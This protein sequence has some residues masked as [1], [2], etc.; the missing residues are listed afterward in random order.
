MSTSTVPTYRGFLNITS[1]HMTKQEMQKSKGFL[2]GYAQNYFKDT[3]RPH[4]TRPNTLIYKLD[5]TGFVCFDTDDKASNDFIMSVMEKYNVPANRNKSVSNAFTPTVD[6]SAHK[7][8][9]WF[10][11]DKKYEKQIGT[12]NPAYPKLDLLTKEIV[13]EPIVEGQFNIQDAPILTDEIYKEIKGAGAVA[14]FSVHAE[15]NESEDKE[16]NEDEDEDEEPEAEA[17]AEQ[18]VSQTEMEARE[19]IDTHTTPKDAKTYTTWRNTIFKIYN[20]FGRTTLGLKMAKYFSAKDKKKY[21]EADVGLFWNKIE[22]KKIAFCE[23]G[24]SEIEMKIRKEEAKNALFE[25]I[26]LEKEEQ[27]MQK[28]MQQEEQ[29]K[30]KSK[31]S[32]DKSLSNYNEAFEKMKAEFEKENFKVVQNSCFVQ[33]TFDEEH[34]RKIIQRNTTELTVA[35]SHL[36]I[37]YKGWEEDK[38]VEKTVP[39]VPMW[40]KCENIRRYERM[41]CYPNMSKCPPT[42]FNLWT[43]F[44]MERYNDRPLVDNEEVRAGVAF[45]RH[46]MSIMCDHEQDTLLEFEKWLAQM[47]QYPEYKSHMPI[48]QSAEGSGKGSFFSLLKK[49]LGIGKVF[50]TESPEEY[51]WGRFNN[52][53][54]TTFLVVMNEISKQM[55]NGGIDKIKGIIDGEHIQIQHKGKGAYPMKSFHRFAGCTNAW[56]GGMTISKGSRRFL[57]CKMS[58]EKKGVV[59]YWAAFR[60]LLEN[61]DVLRGFYNYYKTMQ[62]NRVLPAPM[63]TEFA[64]ELEKLSVDVPTLW[65]KDLVA[66]AKV[67]KTLYLNENKTEYKIVNDEYVIELMGKRSCELLMGWCKDNGY[68]KYETNP[69][70]LGVFL[71][72]KKWAGLIKGRETKYGDT[73]YYRVE[74]LIDELKD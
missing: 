16:Q 74:T 51:V 63:K 15:K 33:E 67:N 59:E 71:K 47:I 11:T 37:K 29:K 62:V 60:K 25:S 28:K 61:I 2:S 26:R 72:T 65:V 38:E 56:D 41:D 34:N 70:K 22:A 6:E 3:T 12:V 4:S 66:D 55:T 64:K 52:M 58:D 18:T 10:K 32:E 23:F 43:P 39:F 7:F 50:E 21:V 30:Q 17:E 49:I 8:H 31:S 35:F 19:Y 48:F 46:H 5:D 68:P 57:M 36:I 1:A 53:M 54:E 27:K 45:L 44:E 73:R 24:L 13:F 9:Y 40:I 69:T 42:C 20:K 14:M